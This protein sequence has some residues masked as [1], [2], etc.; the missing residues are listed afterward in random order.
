MKIHR[1]ILLVII[2][3]GS[4]WRLWNFESRWVL[5]ENNSREL[6]ADRYGASNSLLPPTDPTNWHK[7]AMGQLVRKDL[8]AWAPWLALA[9]AG[10]ATIP[11]FYLVGKS[12]VNERFG[13]ICAT[14]VAFASSLITQPTE[15][16]F[17]SL[18][19]VALGIGT[20][21]ALKKNYWSVP[22]VLWGLLLDGTSVRNVGEM[23]FNNKEASW[24]MAAMV[25]VTVGIVIRKNGWSWDRDW[26]VV[27]IGIIL[28]IINPICWV[29]V[30]VLMLAFVAHVFISMA[31]NK[32]LVLWIGIG[33][34]GFWS[35]QNWD[36]VKSKNKNAVFAEAKAFIDKTYPGVEEK[37]TFYEL[38]N[39]KASVLPLMYL[40]MQEGRLSQ[41]GI[42]VIIFHDLRQIQIYLW[43]K[44]IEGYVRSVGAEDVFSGK[45]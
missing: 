17:L 12:L 31:P 42:P 39:S 6:V 38:D 21:L 16:N 44:G 33:A 15:L 2:M 3:I 30:C 24:V 29:V 23:L 40:Y 35:F 36:L 32:E 18:S 41:E 9:L 11:V 20:W 26:L 14:V 4:F 27:P 28:G 1:L 43:R 13:L 45:Y 22:L 37:I 25:A 34:I 5:N 10:V 19:L 7:Y 8:P